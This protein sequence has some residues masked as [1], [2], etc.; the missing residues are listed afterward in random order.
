MMFIEIIVIS[1]IGTCLHFTYE[2]S[3]HNK[4]VA[5]FSSVNESTWEHIKIALSASFLCTLADGF[6][7][8]SLENYF[9][10]KFLSLFLIIVIIPILFYSYMHF[11]KKA[12]LPIDIIIFYVAIMISQMA[13]YHII[14]LPDLGF[15]YAYLGL[16]GIFVIFGFFMVATLKPIH[17][18]IFRD[19]ITNKYGLKGHSDGVHHKNS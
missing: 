7:Y 2:L 8:G 14:K 18:F 4:N 5:L 19:P 12:I 13:F 11:T 15:I 9:W 16:V 1:V 17:H 10:A 3:N 6:M